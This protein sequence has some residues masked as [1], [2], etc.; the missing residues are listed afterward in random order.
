VRSRTA[1][2]LS[3]KLPEL[4]EGRTR[5]L[6]PAELQKLLLAC[7]PWLRPVVGLA[8]STGMR[9]GELMR[10]RWKDV[11]QERGRI[12]LELTKNGKPRFAY[13]NQLANQVIASLELGKSSDL[14]FP[15]LTPSKLRSHSCARAKQRESRISVFMTCGTPSRRNCA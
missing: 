7:P 10:I 9:R 13:L 15:G 2:L 1:N 8:V 3:V 5:H 14:I 12:L 6:E 11:D 4:P